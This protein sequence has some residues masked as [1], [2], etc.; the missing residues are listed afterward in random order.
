MRVKLVTDSTS[1][2]CKEFYEQENIG[3]IESLLRIDGET[4]RDLS[5]IEREDFLNKL[6]KLE[7]YPYSAHADFQ[8]IIKV[9]E[10]TISDGFDEIFYIGVS[11][12]I[13]NQYEIVEFVSQEYKEKIKITL[14]QSGYMGSS[15]GGMVLIANKLLKEGKSVDEI[16]EIL[17]TN[18]DKIKTM[19]VCDSFKALFKTGKVRRKDNITTIAKY[20]EKTCLYKPIAE[21]SHDIGV[22]NV[23]KAKSKRLALR[24]ATKLMSRELSNEVD[25]DLVFSKIESDKYFSI[26]E[27]KIRKQFRIKEV[28]HWEASPV[29]IWAIGKKSI[30]FALIP[31]F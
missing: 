11:K 19:I 1:C 27:K 20:F 21:I 28:L 31:H 4:K 25:Y 18:K 24:K 6:N 14:F 23:G 10:D 17:N 7:L 16:I 13:T 3:V 22:V 30:K 2:L 29:I 15:Q 9:I 8:D 12:K 5:D 26:I